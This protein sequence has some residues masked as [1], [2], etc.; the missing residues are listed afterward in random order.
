MRN[1]V[2]PNFRGGLVSWRWVCT[3]HGDLQDVMYQGP[4]SP[5]PSDK[6]GIPYVQLVRLGR[7]IQA[8]LAYQ[9]MK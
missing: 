5:T 2:I 3:H 6:R 9:Y 7:R 4:V 1:S 8:G